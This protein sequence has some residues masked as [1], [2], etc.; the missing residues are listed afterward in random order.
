MSQTVIR[1]IA[2]RHFG[3]KAVKALGKKGI[4]IVGLTSIPDP[5]GGFIDS[6]TGYSVSDNGTHRIWSFL[7]V[8]RAAGE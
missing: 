5:S 2:I 7:E 3:S 4:V 6:E 1:Q 8:T